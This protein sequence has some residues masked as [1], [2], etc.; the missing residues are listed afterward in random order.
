MSNACVIALRLPCV[1][2]RSVLSSWQALNSP[3]NIAPHHI[4]AGAAGRRLSLRSFSVTA[5][6]LH[7]RAAAIP[8]YRYYQS[9]VTFLSLS[10]IRFPPQHLAASFSSKRQK[11]TPKHRAHPPASRKTEYDPEEGLPFRSK[12][13][14]K[15]EIQS[16][17]GP[18]V[19]APFGNRILRV[20]HGKRVTGKLDE[21]RFFPEA[22]GVAEHLVANALA[23]LRTN[24]P[25][26]EEAAEIA[27]LE[28]E[29]RRFT[30]EVEKDAER[31]GIYKP[32]Q[33]VKDDN[34]YGR[35][36]LDAL[37]D[38]YRKQQE[39][40]QD[41]GTS[42][43]ADE[44]KANTGALEKANQSSELRRQK[45]AEWVKYYQERAKLTT[46]KVAPNLSRL[47]RLWPS[48][49]V[50]VTVIGLS[51]FLAQSYVPPTKAARLWPEMPPA[52]ATIIGLFV[53]NAVL[54]VA[55]RL[56]PAWLFLN[57]YFMSVPA[58]PYAMSMLGN[59]FSHQQF[60]HFAVNMI[61][62][63]IIGTRLH[64]D[65]GRANFL[66]IYFSTGVFS[67]FVSLANAV[68][69]KNFVTTSI[70]ASGA[71]SGI[72]AAWCSLNSDKGFSFVF[73][74]QDLIP[75]MSSNFVL[76][77]LVAG[78]IYGIRKGWGRV[79]HY[80]HLGGL[81]AGFV[82]AQILKYRARER[83][84]VELERRKNLG[85]VDKIREGRL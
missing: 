71:I 43:Q 47:Q 37:R 69:R 18:T 53:V 3:F 45:N 78:E 57:R 17:L 66:A 24:Y 9:D 35:S 39:P 80:A 46:D 31:I 13:L 70:G 19:E 5:K 62:L 27:R 68:L 77:A 49:L 75:S 29:E 10:R 26:D 52:A 25:I 54:I 36:G 63:W 65:V 76:F 14:S 42:S 4:L 74:P 85:F 84:K 2:T 28:E 6:P 21:G 22:T 32:Q 15:E 82:G 67:S 50:T 16:I 59:V 83:R 23:W 64:D 8:S 55:W 34:V 51:V 12:D 40:Q 20:L 38:H 73:L 30:R 60:T 72:L 44:I 56:P 11:V 33:G 81:G 61:V 7:R 58:Y 41:K 1:G 79:D 48:A